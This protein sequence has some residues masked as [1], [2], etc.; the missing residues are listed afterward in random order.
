VTNLKADRI[1][2]LGQR[3]VGLVVPR[4]RSWPKKESAA[5]PSDSMNLT[6]LFKFGETL[7]ISSWPEYVFLGPGGGLGAGPFNQIEEF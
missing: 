6:D 3:E 5:K 4:Q 7:C 1:Q 2:L